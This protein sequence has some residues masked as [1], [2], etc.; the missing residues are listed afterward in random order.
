MSELGMVMYDETRKLQCS[1]TP[2]NCAEGQWRRLDSLIRRGGIAGGGLK[3]YS[4]RHI[5]FITKGHMKI[6]A[7]K[8]PPLQPW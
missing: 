4:K 5:A 3:G 1:I 6:L 2:Q 8:P 7:H